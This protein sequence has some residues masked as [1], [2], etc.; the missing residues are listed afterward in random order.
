M[1]LLV[2]LVIYSFALYHPTFVSATQMSAKL[3]IRCLNLHLF[4]MIIKIAIIQLVLVPVLHGRIRVAVLVI[5][6]LLVLVSCFLLYLESSTTTASS[7]TT[8]KEN[9]SLFYS[10]WD[11]TVRMRTGERGSGWNTL[12]MNTL[13]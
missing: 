2:S 11:Y 12:L 13:L 9:N 3:Q 6:F 4:D 7:V 1:Y 10:E 5:G 8:R